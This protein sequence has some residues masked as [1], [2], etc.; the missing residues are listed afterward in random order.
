MNILH[1]IFRSPD[2]V[3]SV[4]VPQAVTTPSPA[5]IAEAVPFIQLRLRAFLQ[6]NRVWEVMWVGHFMGSR[7]TGATQATFP[8]YLKFC[9]GS[10]I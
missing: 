8:R 3:H 9:G 10:C 4:A 2:S 5:I 7:D 6:F 1:S